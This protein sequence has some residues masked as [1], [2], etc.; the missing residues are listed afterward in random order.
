MY[1]LVINESDDKAN[2][3]IDC[4]NLKLARELN[5]EIEEYMSVWSWDSLHD[6]ARHSGRVCGF[7]HN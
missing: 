5:D 7:E 2:E 1:Y 3:K 6:E 4:N